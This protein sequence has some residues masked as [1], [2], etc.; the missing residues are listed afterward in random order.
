[1]K[2]ESLHAKRGII[3]YE[4]YQVLPAFYVQLFAPDLYLIGKAIYYI[5][6]FEDPNWKIRYR[7]NMDST[8][9]DPFYY[10][11]EAE[12]DRVRRKT[13]SE[14]DVFLKDILGSGD[15]LV[16]LYHKI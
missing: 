3:T 13:T 4:G 15:F 10:T 2:L 5:Q 12:E 6:K 14:F 11:S 1:M 8:Q 16:C 9:D 7:L